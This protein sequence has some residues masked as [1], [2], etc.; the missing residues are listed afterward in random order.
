VTLPLI[1]AR[2]S[3]IGGGFK[4]KGQTGDPCKTI[5]IKDDKLIKIVCK[6]SSVRRTGC[7]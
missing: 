6:G 7:A 2:W 3:P 1:A 4:Y 5:K